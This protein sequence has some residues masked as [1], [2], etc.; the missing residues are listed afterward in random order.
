MTPF[1]HPGI[2]IHR[3]WACLPGVMVAFR[4]VWSNG[5]RNIAGR[6]NVLIWWGDRERTG[7]PPQAVLRGLGHSILP[8]ALPEAFRVLDMAKEGPEQAVVPGASRRRFP[9][10]QG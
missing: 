3:S 9:S 6:S 1:P 7:F 2:R 4:R 8:I 10:A 5:R